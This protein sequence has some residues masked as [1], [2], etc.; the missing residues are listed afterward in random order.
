MSY[1]TDENIDY[2]Y[3][4]FR[5]KGI[6]TE[7]L[8]NE[9]VDH[10]CCS[11][12]TEIKRGIPFQTAY[13][14]LMNPI[15]SSTF[16]H[17]QHQ[18]L[19]S[20][21]LK[22]QNMKKAMFVSGFIGTILLITGVFFK[23]QHLPGAGV[24]IV[25]GMV[26][27]VFAFLPMFFY[28]SYKEQV[29]KKNII[30]YPIG[31]L[32]LAFLLLGPLFKIMHWPFTNILIFYGPLLLAALFLPVY[33]VSIFRKA[34]ETKTNFLFLIILIGIG[35]STLFS[36][37]AVNISRDVMEKC[38]SAYQQNM[39]VTDLFSVKND[40]LFAQFSRSTQPEPM[41]QQV[42]NIKVNAQVLKN[43]LN[44]LMLKMIQFGNAKDAT[45]TNFSSKDT[46]NACKEILDQ[47]D[48]EKNLR[49]ALEKYK[50]SLQA[51]ASDEYRKQII[52]SYSG[53]NLVNKSIEYYDFKGAPLIV[54]LEKLSTIQKN[55]QIA[56]Y[57]VL[58]TTSK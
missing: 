25:F 3:D 27:I 17:L 42:E 14:N 15:E 4:D 8:L 23:I 36:L 26:T 32:T 10:I 48:N 58:M 1:L 11:I 53:F 43:Q 37:S 41:K 18:D 34:N 57:E 40:S 39:K 54:A 46:K 9:M 7:M 16:K 52:N 29:E 51:F 24:G 56:E 33:L 44:N 5:N 47:N 45:L 50:S 12:E 13:E 35:F 2:I 28:S 38:D 6:T 21:N 49:E 19:L 31:Y 20:T 30:L 55:V 22:F